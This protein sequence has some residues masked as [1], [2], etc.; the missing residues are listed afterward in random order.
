[1]GT[2][3]EVLDILQTVMTAVH[4]DTKE[5]PLSTV[6]SVANSLSKRA[7]DIQPD[8]AFQI[9]KQIIAA[10]TKLVFGLPGVKQTVPVLPV[11]NVTDNIPLDTVASAMS[12]LPT[13][14]ILN[15]VPV[16][17]GLTADLPAVGAVASD[18]P[19]GSL[20]SSLPVNPAGAVDGVTSA[21]PVDNV[22]STLPVSDLAANPAG[23]LANSPVEGVTVPVSNV[24]STLP[25]NSLLGG[26]GK[27]DMSSVQSE[28]VMNI[29]KELLT[30]AAG[31]SK[32][33][34]TAGKSAVKKRATQAG[35]DPDAIAKTLQTILS[36]VFNLSSQIKAA[37]PATQSKLPVSVPAT[38]S[39]P[40]VNPAGLLLPA[41]QLLAPLLAPLALLPGAL[42][43]VAANLP[44]DLPTE[45]PLD[46]LAGILPALNV[47][48]LALP[49]LS[50]IPALPIEFPSNVFVGILPASNVPKVS[51]SNLSSLPPLPTEFPSDVLVG[52]LLESN[53]PGLAL[54]SLLVPSL[55]T[56]L[57]VQTPDLSAAGLPPLLVAS[58]AAPQDL[59]TLQIDPATGLSIE[60]DLPP[61]PSATFAAPQDLPTLQIDPVTGLPIE[62]DLPL[63]K[64]KRDLVAAGVPIDE[65]TT[66]LDLL[67]DIATAMT[68][69]LDG[70]DAVTSKLRSVPAVP[71]LA[72][73]LGALGKRDTLSAEQQNLLSV[74]HEKN[75][76]LQEAL[77]GLKDVHL[78]KR[79][80]LLSALP[81]GAASGVT[82]AAPLDAAGL[83]GGLLGGLH[84]LTSVLP[85]SSPL[86]PATG[87]VGSLAGGLTNAA[88]GLTGGLPSLTSVF[89][90]VVQVLS[91]IVNMLNGG[92]NAGD[93][94]ALTG[95]LS[96]VISILDSLLDIT[97]LIP[98]G[99][100]NGGIAP[101]AAPG[102]P[103][104]L[105]TDALGLPTNVLGGIIP[106][107]LLTNV[108]DALNSALPIG[109]LLAGVP[110]LTGSILAP[111]APGLPA[112]LPNDAL[113]GLVPTALPAG[114]PTSGLPTNVL[115]GIIPTNL[116]TNVVDALNSAAPALPVIPVSA[117][118]GVPAASDLTN[119]LPISKPDTILSSSFA[120]V[121]GIRATLSLIQDLPLS[122]LIP[123][124]GKR[125]GRV[126]ARQLSVLGGAL[127]PA[128]SLTSATNGLTGAVNP[129]TGLI[130][131]TGGLIN[132]LT[133]TTASLVAVAPVVNGVTGTAGSLTNV[134]GSLLAVESV[135][136]S[137]PSLPA[138]GVVASALPAVDGLAGVASSVIGLVGSLT[139]VAGSLP[140]ISSLTSV[141]PAVPAVGG[142][143][144]GLPVI[145]SLPVVL[146]L[147]ATGDL[148][149]NVLAGVV[150]SALPIL[151][152]VTG[153]LP[154][155]LPVVT[156]V[157]GSLPGADAVSVLPTVGSTL[158]LLPA[159]PDL[160]VLS[161][162]PSI[163]EL[164]SLPGLP[165][166]GALS[167][168]FP[169]PAVSD[170]A[171]ILPSLPAV[172]GLPAL[173]SSVSLPGGLSALSS[174]PI[175]PLSGLP[176]PSLSGGLLA[177]TG[178]ALPS[179][180]PAVSGLPSVPSGV[181]A[182]PVVP[183]L[184]D[185]PSL[186]SAPSLPG[187]PALPGLP[188]VPTLT[189]GALSLL[190]LPSLPGVPTLPDGAPTL[191]GVPSLLGGLSNLP[192]TGALTSPL[193]PLT[194]AIA[195]AT[196]LAGNALSTAKNLAPQLNVLQ[197]ALAS[198]LS[199]LQ[200]ILK[201]SNRVTPLTKRDSS[202][203]TYPILYEPQSYASLELGGGGSVPNN[204][205][206][207]VKA[208]A[209]IKR[210]ERLFVHAQ[211][212]I[213][214]R[215]ILTK[216]AV[217]KFIT[218]WHQEGA[219][220]ADAAP[221]TVND[222]MEAFMD[223]SSAPMTATTLSKY[224]D[225]MKNFAMEYYNF[226][227]YMDNMNVSPE[228]KVD[229]LKAMF[230]GFDNTS[231]GKRSMR[232][233][234]RTQVV[235]EDEDQF[236]DAIESTNDMSDV[237]ELVNKVFGVQYIDP[238]AR[239]IRGCRLVLDD[240]VST[241]HGRNGILT[242]RS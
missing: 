54:P 200:G 216:A 61:L 101:P 31:M 192:A 163:P 19:V 162:F 152:S 126:Q 142:L 5:V 110:S 180:L 228:D 172:T 199:K 235:V 183:T 38:P 233:G 107:S 164:P 189:G 34:P 146:G 39:L 231:H 52:I 150:S 26:L 64:A 173:P 71:S 197:Q 33:L 227:Q 191:P 81:L 88:T 59:P 119:I 170:V 139:K 89:S 97:N 204:A 193:A 14:A 131:V 236:Y 35:I 177:V 207:V 43:A 143:A 28:A 73:S 29:A 223:H 130:S 156:G 17:S 144:S 168:L 195:P 184:P 134:A 3:G 157:L 209:G 37:T 232:H 190:G 136:P 203:S 32:E 86:D 60:D 186:L 62:D 20:A 229:I 83:T 112:G 111:A 108:V 198:I 240:L 63:G 151:A 80:D 9:L 135:L 155:V 121:S 77:H 214:K 82:S 13:G 140:T 148:A 194:G 182:A 137:T 241:R 6:K 159:V 65:A 44:V 206:H 8:V 124:I 27:R 21:L 93:A 2:L 217:Q 85:G 205:A 30:M 220:L 169:L 96:T 56:S 12:N 4:V 78:G 92:T 7:L 67:L 167:G 161:G 187:L 211:A 208:P 185:I 120:A 128:T 106:T 46:A 66:I 133:G 171:A 11:P 153:A 87:L 117:L 160:G 175:P 145:S 238:H 178:L 127:K 75:A 215:Q 105:P 138:V 57:P 49:S 69:A 18:L 141:L 102:L 116:P 74:A 42:P 103:A 222:L 114:I 221:G 25:V 99:G 36:I 226:A 123:G 113:G 98:S 230:D 95:I 158:P 224:P 242:E 212:L 129:A 68:S 91:T 213:D 55:S 90:T 16:V 47:P 84:G 118:S 23:V 147:P 45:A 188:G 104:G 1:M 122:D 76:K 50:D 174:L 218:K 58:F 72:G 196:N 202:V 24:A 48:D 225:S 41:P 94:S 100:S 132:G 149:E 51:P 154:T 237:S 125:D 210:H 166:L 40:S 10:A 176:P 239:R 109:S 179:D 219:A 22:A 201:T 234:S 79:Q 165:N 115:G 53:V 70:T 15:N 181:P